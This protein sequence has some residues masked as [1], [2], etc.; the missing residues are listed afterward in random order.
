MLEEGIWVGG[1]L[2]G[3]C[4]LTEKGGACDQVDVLWSI[5]SKA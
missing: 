4:G 2:Q 3:D 5:L 1:V